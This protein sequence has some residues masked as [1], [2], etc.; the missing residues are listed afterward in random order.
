VKNISLITHGAHG[1]HGGIDKY[2]RNIIDV[3]SKTENK[4]YVNIYSKN[5]VFLNKKNVS[6]KFSKNFYFFLLLRN[7]INIIKS[8]LIIVTHIN[9]IL[10]LFFLIFNKKKIILFSY[11]L[12]I[13]GGKKNILY[14]VFIKKINYFICMRRYTLNIQKKIYNLKPIKEYLLKNTLD[15]LFNNSQINVRKQ[16][17]LTV[18]RLDKNEKYKGIDETLEAMALIKKINFKYYIIGDGDDR[19]RLFQKAKKL[20]INKHVI[21]TGR[22]SDQKRDKMFRLSK[23]CIM[24][25]TDKTFDTY[26]Y[27]FSF[28]E[29]ASHGLHVIGSM[30]T[31][32]ELS[33]AKKY[34][35]FNFVNAFNRNEIAR[36]IIQLLKKKNLFCANLRKD[37]SFDTFNLDLS[38]ILKKILNN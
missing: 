10:Y 7:I 4:Y 37:F 14:R 34:K 26:P 27:R 36:K 23:I 8:D 13:W 24:P 29:A 17:I 19:K 31:K 38:I 3:I 25:G 1:G 18:A 15:S 28:L 35:N 20:N 30:P 16:I 12:D 5:K 22:I 6:T 9:L 32:L 21:F 11:G 2:T 33:E